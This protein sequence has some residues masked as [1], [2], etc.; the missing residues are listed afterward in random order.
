LVISDHGHGEIRSDF[1]TN[2]WLE[3]EGFLVLHSQANR[4]SRRVFGRLSLAAQKIPPARWASRVLAD[5]LREGAGADLANR[6][7]GD[8]SFESV[9]P[10]IDWERTVAY[11][12]PVPEGIYL[13]PHNPNL[14][15]GRRLEVLAKIRERLEAYGDA[16]IEVLG[17]DQLYAG[18][19]LSTAPSLLIRV[20]GMRTEPRMDFSYPHPLIRDR[21]QYFCGSGTHRMDGILIGAGDGV[22]AGS[23]LGYVRIVDLAP[24]ILEGMG[25]PAPAAWNGR[26]FGSR[27]GLGA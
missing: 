20:D 3:E 26:S 6:V 14:T 18:H 19:N 2:R 17:P 9:H 25:V 16:R 24:T 8:A 15:A 4:V 27:L 5:F 12:Y 1:F 23:D 10:H 7:V 21:P 13:N 22:R 11:S